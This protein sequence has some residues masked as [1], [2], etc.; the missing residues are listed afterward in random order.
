[1]ESL[2]AFISTT[3]ADRKGQSRLMGV[4]LT[5]HVLPV[6]AISFFQAHGVESSS[7]GCNES[8]F[9][10]CLPKRVPEFQR[11]VGA[12]V[13]FISQLP[14]IGEPAERHWHMAEICAF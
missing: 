11:E 3:L 2:S 1:M 13:N 10:S 12:S 5:V 14:N 8:V 6:T 7:A 9:F 4:V